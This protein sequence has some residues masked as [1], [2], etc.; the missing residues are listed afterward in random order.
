MSNKIQ[1]AMKA[2]S[3]AMNED[4][5]YARSWHSNISVQM[6]DSGCD[7]EVA[8]EGASRFMK[9]AFNVNVKA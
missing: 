4:E 8:N 2:L 6:Q 5:D 9:L 1:K 3:E 7:R